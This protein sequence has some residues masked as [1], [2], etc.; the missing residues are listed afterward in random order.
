MFRFIRCTVVA[1]SC[2]LGALT[3]SAQSL[4]EGPLPPI[5]GN[6]LQW[7][8]WTII[9]AYLLGVLA[10]GWYYARKQKDQE[11]YFIA[12]RKPIHP[13]LIGISL[14]ATL[15]STITYLGKPGEM[16][17]KGPFLIVGQFLS[18]PF[19]ILI[20]GW[21]IIPVLMKVRATSAYELLEARLGA[22]VRLTGSLMFI[23]LRIIWMSVLIYI[24]S[25]VLITVMGLDADM[26]Y[27]VTILA[28]T[29]S[30][31]YA[32][33][34]GLRTVVITD[35]IQFGLLF[36]GAV[37]TIAIV[38]AST[39]GIG[40]VPRSWSPTWDNQPWFSWDPTVRVTVFNVVIAG[41]VW[42]VATYGSDQTSVQRFM[43]TKDIRAA[44]RSFI[45]TQ[46]AT[47][48]VMVVLGALGFALLG[49]FTQFPSALGEGMTIANDA[50]MLYPYF[51]AHY[52][53]VGITGLV[54]SGTLA[55]AMSSID[56]GVNS[57][58]A[59]VAKDIL[60][61]F[62]H[63][64][65]ASSNDIRFTCW[66]AAGIGLCIVALSFI[67]Q[68]IPGN[69]SEMTNRSVNLLV[70][71]IFAFFVLALWVPFATPLGAFLGCVAGI[72]ASVLV[73]FWSNFTGHVGISY[74]FI[75]PVTLTAD[76][77]VALAVSKWGPP[78]DEARRTQ[79]VGWSGTC[80]ILVLMVAIVLMGRST[81]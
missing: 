52:L 19:V 7:L 67:T 45:V 14:F 25:R 21:I 62:K 22:K 1:L 5:R 64:P 76:L 71:P 9:I 61:R 27:L 3:T 32:A 65:K 58:T 47:L 74:H 60:P 73:S 81:A 34:G 75:G 36:M 50:D 31:T 66:M 38:T 16:I 23:C 17:N 33:M 48:I 39:G 68:H 46:L 57:I 78:R 43:A 2:S 49:F 29:V 44:R 30:I 20:V 26:T 51:I 53:P 24:S 42:H 80:L 13:T 37:L 54:I 72:G 59:V 12:A 6:G 70:Q 4:T 79:W 35:V 56:S 40:W 10:I 41:I 28:A 8:D 11:E 15:M 63:L 77:A 55:A 69:I 18:I